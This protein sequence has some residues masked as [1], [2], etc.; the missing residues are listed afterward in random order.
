MAI[1]CA[2]LAVVEQATH[3]TIEPL[4]VADGSIALDLNTFSSFL[5]W[6]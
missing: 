3:R 2:G 4:A 6:A 1:G 5:G